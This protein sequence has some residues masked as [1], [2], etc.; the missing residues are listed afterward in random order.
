M[1]KTVIVL[2]ICLLFILPSMTISVM[3][4]PEPK[5][6]VG[7]FGASFLSG[8][9][10]IGGVIYNEGDEMVYDI[11]WT[12]SVTGGSDNSINVYRTEAIGDLG[13]NAAYQFSTNEVTGFGPVTITFTVTSSNAER[14]SETIHG[15]QVGPITLSKTWVSCWYD[16]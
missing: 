5:V 16:F 7:A 12:L 8:I 1:K 13:L 10:R 14:E 6:R 3:A 4:D 11:E 9:R 2:S 15:F